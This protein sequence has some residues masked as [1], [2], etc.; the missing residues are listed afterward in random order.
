MVLKT[1]SD[2]EL[3]RKIRKELCG[4]VFA[5]CGFRIEGDTI[6]TVTILSK[7]I[8]EHDE[9]VEALAKNAAKALLNEVKVLVMQDKKPS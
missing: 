9:A 6:Q 8:D 5:L 4:K 2:Y 1:K 7:F 3:F